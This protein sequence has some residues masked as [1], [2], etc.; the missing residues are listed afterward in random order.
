MMDKA[1]TTY[2]TMTALAFCIIVTCITI[3]NTYFMDKTDDPDYIKYTKTK[4]DILTDKINHILTTQENNKKIDELKTKIAE[5][6]Y[7]INRT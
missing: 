2:I 1:W 3:Y 7:D 6:D 4:D 5:L